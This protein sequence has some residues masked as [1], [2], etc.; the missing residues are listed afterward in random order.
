MPELLIVIALFA[1]LGG[2]SLLLLRNHPTDVEQRNA[3]RQTSVAYIIQA[4][5]NYH[6]KYHELPADIPTSD[7]YIENSENGVDICPALVPEFASDLPYDPT[8]GGFTVADI[9]TAPNQEYLTAFTIRRSD[10]S[11]SITVSA[12]GAEAGKKISITKHFK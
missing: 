4:L 10:D 9:C 1:V 6:K 11:K 3:E 7:A 12:P 5:N 8:A 2:I